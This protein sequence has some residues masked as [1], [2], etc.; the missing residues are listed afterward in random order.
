VRY[1]VLVPQTVVDVLAALHLDG[2]IAV[3]ALLTP[4]VRPVRSGL[5]RHTRNPGSAHSG[6]ARC[7]ACRR[8]STPP[9]FCFPR[10]TTPHPTPPQCSLFSTPV[11][12]FAERL[13]DP[14]APDDNGGWDPARARGWLCFPRPDVS[15]R[16]AD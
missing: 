6:P 9:P 12:H 2:L 10:L 15:T 3:R 11:P 1:G 14:L 8:A 13:W 7:I 16:F 5:A 4:K